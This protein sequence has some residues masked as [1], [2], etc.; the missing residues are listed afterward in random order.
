MQ[1]YQA[2]LTLSLYDVYENIFFT[3][4]FM[5]HRNPISVKISGKYICLTSVTRAKPNE[6]MAFPT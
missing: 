3:P 5:L 4:K 6:K 1:Q 2:I